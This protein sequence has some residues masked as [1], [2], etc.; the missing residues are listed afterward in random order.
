VNIFPATGSE[1]TSFLKEIIDIKGIIV[2]IEKDSKIPF[3]IKNTIKK[4]N[5]TFLSELKKNNSLYN[6]LF[7]IDNIIM[8]LLRKLYYH[9]WK[10]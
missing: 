5:W 10:I 9:F 3:N 4:E 7:L 8:K 1:L 2:A 6:G